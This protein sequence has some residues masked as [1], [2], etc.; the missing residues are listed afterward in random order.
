MAGPFLLGLVSDGDIPT[1]QRLFDLFAAFADDHDAAFRANAVDCVE[2]VEKQGTRRDR[3]EDLVR[4]GAHSSALP[5]S[6][7]HDREIR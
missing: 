3:V 6:K 4:V 7:N 1:V 2:K 5:S